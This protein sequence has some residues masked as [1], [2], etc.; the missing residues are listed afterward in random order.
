MASEREAPTLSVNL[1]GLVVG[2]R[3]TSPAARPNCHG[4]S[5]IHSP[6]K[7][8][9]A[10]GGVARAP[11]CRFM[12]KGGGTG[13]SNASRGPYRIAR[14]GLGWL[15]S[16]LFAFAVL[17]A[18]AQAQSPPAQPAQA[19]DYLIVVDTSFSMAREKQALAESA[20]NLIRSTIAGHSQP[21]AQLRLWTFNEQVHTGRF[22]PEIWTPDRTEI[23]ADRAGRFLRSQRF[24]KRTRLD[25]A[26]AEILQA[27]RTSKAMTVFLLSDG[28][29]TLI[30]T[31]FDR[32]LNLLYRENFRELQRARKPFI[33]ALL[34][35]DGQFVA[36]SVSTEAKSVKVPEL[37]ATT[38]TARAAVPAQSAGTNA[39]PITRAA[40][41]PVK[42]SNARSLPGQTEQAAT[43]AADDRT[44]AQIPSKLNDSK[45]SS[46]RADA[47]AANKVEQLQTTSTGPG[48]ID[49]VPVSASPK[50]EQSE[51]PTVAAPK[52]EA[53]VPRPETTSENPSPSQPTNLENVFAKGSRRREEA[54]S[55]TE[56]SA[57]I[58]LLASAA[59]NQMAR[60]I[61]TESSAVLGQ[62]AAVAAAQ[63][64]SSRSRLAFGG[65]ALLLIALGLLYWS[66]RS[67]RHRSGPSLISKSLDR[68]RK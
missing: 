60:Q 52:S 59:T 66:A 10:A 55:D 58:S 35:R 48:G 28:D 5:L 34:A 64:V 36:W 46:T 56:K 29:T 38:Q 18:Q 9:R 4:R 33:T 47:E 31:P 61:P 57:E 23:I 3:A 45:P 49:S 8:R 65:I 32:S 53:E 40:L 12:K 24:E 17:K 20:T 7:S 44:P 16:G 39:A 67:H 21:G 51:L 37:P 30:G 1:P 2:A 63:T 6:Q 22:P 43:P 13:S 14:C 26:V 68:E 19:S 54:D 42:Q 41:E 11:G 25:K 62:A 50:R 27:V 15:A